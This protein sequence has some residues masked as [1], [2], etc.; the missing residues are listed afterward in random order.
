MKSA[1][2]SS[3]NGSTVL[4]VDDTSANLGVIVDSLVCSGFQVMIAQDG[5]EALERVA[6]TRPDLIL[7]DVL[8]PGLNA[9]CRFGPRMAE[10]DIAG[11]LAK[12]T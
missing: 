5:E 6:Y 7:L 1:T 10:R 12:H 3:S 9:H 2:Q 4:I 8:M 11:L